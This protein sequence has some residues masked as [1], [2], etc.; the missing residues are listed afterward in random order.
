MSPQLKSQGGRGS[1][2]RW[3]SM[4]FGLGAGSLLGYLLDPRLGRRRR[5]VARDRARRT[6]HQVKLD[7]IKVEHDLLN[8]AHGLAARLRA[9]TQPEQAS[10]EVVSERV[11]AALGRACSRASAIEVSVLDGRA[12]LCG[13]ILEREYVPVM[14]AVARVRGVGSIED[15]LDRHV[16]PDGSYALRHDG[17][18][19]AMRCADVMKTEVQTVGPDDTAQWAC[20]KMTWA[21]VGFLPVCDAERRVIGVITDRDI[22][23]RVVA[24]GI[25]PDNA[26]VGDCMTGGAVMC[27]P[28]DDLAT[29]E[30]LMAQHQISRIVIADGRGTLMGVISLSDLA[31]RGSVRRAARTLRAVAAREA[32]RP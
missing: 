28:T 6:A 17:T 26:R 29:A 13:T 14:R 10:D 3:G 8:R 22:V 21:N 5:A 2:T 4:V 11:R 18:P 31:E 9:M 23:V 15:Q 30:R 27:A 25:S 7:A 12:T 32:P 24:K 20:E 19:H 1:G 16:T